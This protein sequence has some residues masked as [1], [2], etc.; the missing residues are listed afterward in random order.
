MPAVAPDLAPVVEAMD[1]DPVS[2]PP[3]SFYPTT[4]EERGWPQRHYS[5]LKDVLGPD[6]HGPS[7]SHT[8]GPQ[9]IAVAAFEALGGRPD[10]TRVTLFNSFATTGEG[11][12]TPVAVVAGLMGFDTTDPRTPDA[13]YL[14]D[15]AGM[16]VE[17]IPLEDPNEHPNAMELE[18]QRGDRV[19]QVK[20]VSIGGGNV[21]ITI[22]GE[23]VRDVANAA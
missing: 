6:F 3:S 1:G 5:I 19:I 7:S 18:L 22:N 13:I 12:K 9:K 21:D 2:R 20:G 16:V 14:A 4:P 17:F 15:E 10:Y 8:A 23:V 11:H